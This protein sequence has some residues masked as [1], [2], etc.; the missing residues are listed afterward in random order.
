MDLNVTVGADIAAYEAGMRNVARTAVTTGTSVT[1]SLNEAAQ[2]TNTL[3]NAAM[4]SSMRFQTMRSGISAARDGVLAF[5]VGGQAA[6]RSLLAMGHHI[7]SLVNETGSFKGAMGA[8]ASSLWGP[9]GIILGLSLAYEI[10][11]KMSEKTK[12]LTESEKAYKEALDSAKSS[13]ETE[14]SN[15][16]TLYG[17]TQNL[18]LS[19]SDRLKAV[20]E[21]KSQYPEYFSHLTKEAILAGEAAAAYDKLTKSMIGKAAI[22]IASAKMK[23]SMG[24][25]VE[26]GIREANINA[27]IDKRT[28]G[29]SVQEIMH[30]IEKETEKKPVILTVDAFIKLKG[31]TATRAVNDVLQKQVNSGISIK[32]SQEKVEQTAKENVKKWQDVIQNLIKDFGVNTIID[33]KDKKDKDAFEQLKQKATDLKKALAAGIATNQSDSFLKVLSDQL[34]E[35]NKEIDYVE[36][37]L[38]KIIQS[39]KNV[40]LIAKF[41]RLTGNNNS[42]SSS[43]DIGNAS[44]IKDTESGAILEQMKAYQKLAIAKDEDLVLSKEQK[45][46]M[47]SK[48]KTIANINNLLGNGLVSAFQTA[49]SGTQSFISAMGEFLKT[50]IE[51]LIAA[52]AAAAILAVIIGIATGGGDIAAEFAKNGSFISGFKT[53]SGVQ[54]ASGGITTGPTH[55]LIGEGAEKEAVMPLSKLQSLINLNGNGSNGMS[56]TETVWRGADLVKQLNR[57]NKQKLRIG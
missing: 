22:E 52:A 19:Y 11:S 48:A 56:T 51:K 41:N 33:G 40:P 20:K 44:G 28:G 23:E 39:T 10:Y 32:E 53:M 5:S 16:S 3:G 36:T 34:K 17:A 27:D 1:Q 43:N 12:E 50:L 2:S 13:A 24:P 15:A 46:E 45:K 6:D 30:G 38:E 55:A 18:N 42:L 8:L 21:L 31:G 4:S 26:Q 57:A 47:D 7:T 9:G 14:I 35:V 29:K 25:L 37:N 49:L 54:L